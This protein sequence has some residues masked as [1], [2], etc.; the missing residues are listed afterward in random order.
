MGYKYDPLYVPP[1]QVRTMRTKQACEDYHQAVRRAEKAYDVMLDLANKLHALA[2]KQ[3]NEN[4]ARAD[5]ELNEAF[6]R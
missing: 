4:M 2:R 5:R 1:D 6:D 3:Y